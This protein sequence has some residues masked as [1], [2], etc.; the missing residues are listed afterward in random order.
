MARRREAAPVPAL[1]E[2]EWCQ[3]RQWRQ[4]VTGLEPS[5]ATWETFA[6][7]PM[8]KVIVRTEA[9]EPLL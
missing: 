7:R 2:C 3:M 5:P 9:G 4:D 1:C 6:G 8:R